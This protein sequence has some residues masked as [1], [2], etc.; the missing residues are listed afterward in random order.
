MLPFKTTQKSWLHLFLI[1]LMVV[2]ILFAQHFEPLW[3]TIIG[4][5]TVVLFLFHSLIVEVDV[6]YLRI[7]YGPGLLQK[8]I[9]IGEIQHCRP[10]QNSDWY[11]FGLI[12]FGTDFTL[13]NV[14]GKHAVE[15]TLSHKQRKIRVGTDE[16]DQVCRAIDRAQNGN[17]SANAP[18]PDS[19]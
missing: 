8:K 9:K 2:L 3:L 7:K 18:K 6:K 10:V 11:S 4:G 19:E 15:L 12:R 1:P 13:Y 5:L 14:S 17:S 16:P